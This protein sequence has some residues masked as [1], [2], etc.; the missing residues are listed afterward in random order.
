M[1]KTSVEITGLKEARETYSAD[2]VRRALRSAV[3]RG[4]TFGK[5]YMAQSVADN[6]NVKKR[7]AT[8]AIT[9]RRTTMASM[10]IWWIIKGKALQLYSYFGAHQDAGGV[11]VNISRSRTTRIPH[12]FIQTAR[13]GNNPGWRGVMI[14]GKTTGYK[15][16]WEKVNRKKPEYHP[17]GLAG[18]SIP[19][20]IAP[21]KPEGFSIWETAKEKVVSFVNDEFWAQI[22]KRLT[23]RR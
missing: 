14:R 16:P 6:Y 9:V 5:Q 11:Y 3:D 12:A 17:R 7:D 4:G 20:L 8:Q 1:L 23:V 22:S 2:F 10:E 13:Q 19:H 21:T 18:P 15:R